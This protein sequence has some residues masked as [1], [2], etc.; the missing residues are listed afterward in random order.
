M[1]APLATHLCGVTSLSRSLSLSLPIS[2]LCDVNV[3]QE[4]DDE[5]EDAAELDAADRKRDMLAA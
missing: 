4:N 5:D 1:F 3:Q 2:R